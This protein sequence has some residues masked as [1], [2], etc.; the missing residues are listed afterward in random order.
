MPTP[1]ELSGSIARAV[2]EVGDEVDVDDVESGRE[3]VADLRID[4]LAMV[5]IVVILEEEH[6]IRI[7][8]E[9]VRTFRRV[10]DL[11]AYLASATA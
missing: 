2:A 4:S 3:F 1:A 5:E 11:E 6:G 9:A 10:G 8:D 7:P